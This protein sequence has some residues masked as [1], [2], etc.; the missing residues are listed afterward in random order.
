MALNDNQ[1]S[2]TF[3]SDFNSLTYLQS[4]NTSGNSLTGTIPSDV[5]ARSMTITGDAPNCPNAFDGATGQYLAGCCDNVLV[6]VDLYLAEFTAEVLGSSN[7][8]SLSGTEADVCS[9]MSN[10]SNHAVF[11]G[12]YPTSFNGNVWEWLKVSF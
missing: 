5:C 9:Y 4:L 12:G 10:K 2:G 3:P 7:C 11:S 6:D 8:G 1:L